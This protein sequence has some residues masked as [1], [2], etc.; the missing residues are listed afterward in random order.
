[1]LLF[2]KPIMLLI[3]LPDSVSV[4]SPDTVNIVLNGSTITPMEKPEALDKWAVTPRQQRKRKAPDSAKQIRDKLKKSLVYEDEFLLSDAFQE[5]DGISDDEIDAV[6][7][8]PENVDKDTD[9]ECG[10]DTELTDI[11][12]ELAKEVSGTIEINTTQS[13]QNK[14][15][16]Y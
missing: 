7:L 15:K 12:L 6:L 5:C 10:N 1:M 2:Y 9:N 16:K 11:S 8:P 4:P 14:K 13:D 3:S